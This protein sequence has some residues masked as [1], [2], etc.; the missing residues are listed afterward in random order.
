MPSRKERFEKISREAR[1]Q[2]N[3]KLAGEL[4]SL[5]LFTEEDVE[6]LLPRKIDK[7]R[8][9]RLMAIVSGKS[10]DNEKVMALRENLDELGQ[11]LL[12]VLR[13]LL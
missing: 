4:S 12:R 6:R 1:D 7:E 8:F 3:R 11:I 9:G 5:T 13:E 2:T 10:S